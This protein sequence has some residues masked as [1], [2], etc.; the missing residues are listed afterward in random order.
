MKAL[1][2]LVLPVLCVGCGTRSALA[3]PTC[4]APLLTEPAPAWPRPS[5]PG[6]PAPFAI[7]AY[8]GSVRA[9]LLG[10]KEDGL[11]MLRRPLGWALARAVGAASVGAATVCLVPVPSASAARRRR[12][13][14]VVRRLADVAAA[15]LRRAGVSATVM[16]VLRHARA[17]SDSAGLGAEDRAR[18]LAGAFAVRTRSLGRLR[19]DPVILVD[20]LITTGVTLTE[21]A[22]ALAREGVRASACATVA[23]TRRRSPDSPRGSAQL[24]RWALPSQGL[25]GYQPKEGTPSGRRREG[26]AHRGR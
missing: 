4:L 6:L 5:P 13:E 23:A 26:P 1:L 2:D 20:D 18:N 16:P 3:C 17:V 22:A 15:E 25:G 7:T 19:T 12:G 10:L 14:D 9:M 24:A 21:C 11:L 8:D